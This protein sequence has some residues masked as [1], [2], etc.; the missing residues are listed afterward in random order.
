MLFRSSRQGSRTNNAAQ[1]K[2]KARVSSVY[3]DEELEYDSEV[4]I[5]DTKTPKGQSKMKKPVSTPKQKAKSTPVSPQ[6][7]VSDFTFNNGVEGNTSRQ[8]PRT[9]NTAQSKTKTR[10]SPVHDDEEHDSQIPIDDPP[11]PKR[12][13]KKK[14]SF[15][16]SK[17]KVK[18]TPVPVSPQYS[19]SGF[20]FNN[21]SG[22]MTNMDIGNIYSSSLS[23]AYNDNSVNRRRK[24]A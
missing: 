12:Q 7:S 17:Q 10:V 16:T 22:N 13:S 21:G 23:D 11:A 18:S 9:K 20:T 1:S 24:P 14:K 4:P 6:Y 3:D 8:G 5:D 19:I 2:T 15:S